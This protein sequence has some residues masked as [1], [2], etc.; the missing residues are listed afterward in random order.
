MAS[1]AVDEGKQQ[2]ETE[3]EARVDTGRRSLETQL[4]GRFVGSQS[5]VSQ[6]MKT[7]AFAR[8]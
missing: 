7:E 6:R 3:R 1:W 2:P 5:W 8:G 4:T